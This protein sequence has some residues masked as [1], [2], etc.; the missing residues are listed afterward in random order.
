[1]YLTFV[2]IRYVCHSPAAEQTTTST[3]AEQ[4]TTTTTAE[5]TTTTSTTTS[6][7]A[8]NATNATCFIPEA[9][10][11]GLSGCTVDTCKFGF[12]PNGVGSACDPCGVVNATSYGSNCTV[13]GCDDPYM[14]NLS[15]DKC[16]ECTSDD[17]CETGHVCYDEKC[18]APCSA[19]WRDHKG[20]RQCSSTL[21]CTAIDPSVEPFY[22][23]NVVWAY[24][25]D[26]PS[27][28]TICEHIVN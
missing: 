22:F 18:A 24:L 9:A 25:E 28:N 26:P 2:N 3:T 16:V 27:D 15:G 12:K 7:N 5:Q 13:T 23:S 8:T 1:M 19:E 20:W 17:H 21:N 14:P 10:I 11:Y 6:T 4:T